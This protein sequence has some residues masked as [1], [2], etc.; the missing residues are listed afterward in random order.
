MDL[1][2]RE[3]TPRRFEGSLALAHFT[4]ACPLSALQPPLSGSHPARTLA[5]A[6]RHLP[7]AAELYR[8]F[9]RRD[10]LLGLPEAAIAEAVAT[11]NNLSL[12]WRWVGRLPY[13]ALGPPLILGNVFFH[14]AGVGTCCVLYAHLLSPRAKFCEIVAKLCQ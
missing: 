6:G 3:S 12:C 11:L 4:P 2:N 10:A 8:Q 14:W 1:R 13:L 9:L 5:L 7:L